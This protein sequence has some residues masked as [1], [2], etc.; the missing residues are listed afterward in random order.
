MKKFVLLGLFIL[1]LPGFAA[2]R[3]FTVQ[4][5]IPSFHGMTPT[6]NFVA[7]S[8]CDPYMVKIDGTK[9][10]LMFETG[11]GY[12]YKNLLGCTGTRKYDMFTPLRDLEKDNDTD[13]L[14]AAELKN[15]GIRLV[16]RNFDGT[17]AVNDKTKDYNLDNVSYIDMT[18]LR[19]TPSAVGYGSFDL[20]IKKESGS[21]K[22]II[23]KV[24]MM[25]IRRAEKMY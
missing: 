15:S 1:G 7:H 17:L 13:K 21:L 6:N 10:Y 25:P 5:G 19:I 9:Y 20:Y 14:T 23:G 2:S 16:A 18:R 11:G 4:Q 8:S 3:Y 12:T 22:K 24:Q